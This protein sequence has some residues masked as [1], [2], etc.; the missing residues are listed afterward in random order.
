MLAHSTPGMVA[1]ARR[2]P[3]G[4]SVVCVAIVTDTIT[5]DVDLPI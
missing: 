2:P 3:P 1:G 4:A 5:F